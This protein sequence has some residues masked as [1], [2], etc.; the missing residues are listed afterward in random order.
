MNL[1]VKLLAVGSTG[2]GGPLTIMMS[3]YNRLN[4]NIVRIKVMI[5]WMTLE[6]LL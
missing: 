3:V 4:N 2:S 1:H 6:G 5:R